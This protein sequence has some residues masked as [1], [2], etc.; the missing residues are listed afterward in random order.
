MSNVRR[1]RFQAAENVV[2]QIVAKYDAKSGAGSYV[3]FKAMDSVGKTFRLKNLCTYI[4]ETNSYLFK[5][6]LYAF[7]GF[8]D[9]FGRNV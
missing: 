8:G 9:L 2:S 3:Q 1:L 7:W 4:K 6:T 5:A